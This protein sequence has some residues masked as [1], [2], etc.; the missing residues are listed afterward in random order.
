MSLS[1]GLALLALLLLVMF[2]KAG[3]NKQITFT[4]YHLPGCKYCKDAMPAWERLRREYG[5]PIGL[6]KID[7]SKAWTE[8]S[9]LGINA[10]PAYV[11]LDK[12]SGNAY[13]YDGER[14]AAAFQ[15]FLRGFNK[16]NW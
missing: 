5:G 13:R 11:L 8:V 7:A 9:S 4:F 12:R 1:L 15:Q 10:F 14:S 3:R 16:S 6:R 2:A